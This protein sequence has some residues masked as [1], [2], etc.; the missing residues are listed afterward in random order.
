ML[1]ISKIFALFVVFAVAACSA[2]PVGSETTSE[3]ASSLESCGAVAGGE[4]GADSANAMCADKHYNG[5][6]RWNTSGCTKNGSTCTGTKFLEEYDKP[7]NRWNPVLDKDGKRTEK[8]CASTDCDPPKAE[9]D[10]VSENV[11]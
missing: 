10:A 11:E 8:A 4:L 7:G 6:Q 2:G 3:S 9:V 5:D 1:S